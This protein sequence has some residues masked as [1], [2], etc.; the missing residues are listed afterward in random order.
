[1]LNALTLSTRPLS[2]WEAPIAERST[3]APGTEAPLARDLAG[4][5]DATL[6]G[7]AAAGDRR[8]FDQLAV[9]H[10]PLL[11]RV[12]LRI[13]GRPAEAEEVAQEAMLRL[14]QNAAKFDP[15]RAQLGSWLYRITANLAIDRTR[16]TRFQ[17]LAEAEAAPDPA[18]G[19]EAVL[20]ARQRRALLAA[21]LQELPP[22]QRAA[23]A[24]SYDQGLS[25]AEAAAALSISTRA[26]EGL[27]R[28][29]RHFLSARLRGEEE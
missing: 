25:G 23:L 11:Y 2:A 27:L 19:P 8:A 7:W 3:P 13:T 22:R 5:E 12:A 28:R 20:D 29:A 9:R 15:T 21:A 18:P 17:P 16:R 4:A 10:L 1:M 24:L 26:L 14:W 6:L